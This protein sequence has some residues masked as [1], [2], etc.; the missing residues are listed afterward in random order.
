MSKLDKKELGYQIQALFRNDMTLKELDVSCQMGEESILDQDDFEAIADS[1][2]INTKLTHLNLSG[3]KIADEDVEYLARRLCH[4]KRLQSLNL[5]NTQ[6]TEKGL[7]AL[8]ALMF[9]NTQ[10]IELDFDNIPALQNTQSRQHIRIIKQALQ[11]NREYEQDKRQS[12]T[13]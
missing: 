11:N 9:F 5:A 2:K 1:L 6:I 4:N 13:P 10:I 12:Y 3:N 8:S 7:E